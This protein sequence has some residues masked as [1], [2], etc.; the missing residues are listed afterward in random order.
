MATT[1]NLQI[2]DGDWHLVELNPI[3]NTGNIDMEITP[4]TIG[5]ARYAYED[6]T[7]EGHPFNKYTVLIDSDIYVKYQ[8]ATAENPKNFTISRR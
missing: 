7:S 2:S 6:T 8:R 4:L 5:S 3:G 1:E